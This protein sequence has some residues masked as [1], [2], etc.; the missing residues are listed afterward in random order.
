MLGLAIGL[1][2]GAIA[3]WCLGKVTAAITGG[4]AKDAVLPLLG[5]MAAIGGGLL[6]TA[7]TLRQQLASAGIGMAAVLIGGAVGIFIA[8]SRKPR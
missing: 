6:I 7:F 5:N 3:L 4:D 1:V 8:R 2:C